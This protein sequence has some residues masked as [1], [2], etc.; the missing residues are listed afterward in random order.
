M[1]FSGRLYYAA[2]CPEHTASYALV[3]DF[4]YEMLCIKYTLFTYSM[5]WCFDGVRIA[6]NSLLLLMFFMLL[7]LVCFFGFCCSLPVYIV[8]NFLLVIFIDNHQLIEK[9]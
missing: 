9:E 2:Q 4:V 3:L 5:V 7:E 8:F 6:L 1:K